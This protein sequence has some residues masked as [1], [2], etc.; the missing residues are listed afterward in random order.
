[1][2]KKYAFQW[3]PKSDVAFEKLKLAMTKASV[4]LLLDFSKTFVV[5]CDAF[6]LGVG[7]VLLQDILSTYCN[8]R[9]YWC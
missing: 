2:L 9:C 5:K 3:N 7:A 6:D 8:T 4:L 1:M